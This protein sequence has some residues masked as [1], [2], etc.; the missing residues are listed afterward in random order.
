MK[1]LR[2]RPR[3]GGPRQSANPEDERNPTDDAHNNPTVP[4]DTQPSSLHHTETLN[5]S[6]HEVGNLPTSGREGDTVP[7]NVSPSRSRMGS[8]RSPERAREITSGRQGSSPVV[9]FR[10]NF[11]TQPQT[12]KTPDRRATTS[13]M[14]PIPTNRNDLVERRHNTTAVT[15]GEM[16]VTAESTKKRKRSSAEDGPAIPSFGAEY[17][18]NRKRR[19]TDYI[20]QIVPSTPNQSPPVNTKTVD[21]RSQDSTS[22]EADAADLETA[23][24][25][26][27]TSRKTTSAPVQATGALTPEEEANLNALMELPFP[28][29][30][31]SDSEDLESTTKDDS[32][33]KAV[34]DLDEWIEERL[35]TRKVNEEQILTALRCTTMDQDLADRVLDYLAAGKGI[36][37]DMRGVW[38]AEDDVS[39]EGTDARDIE[40]LLKKHGTKLYNKRFKY[41]E[42]A[43][44]TMLTS[45]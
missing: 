42:I 28:P 14:S 33:E 37:R 41:L 31:T 29:I 39:L 8:A 24:R 40:R 18:T 30:L 44:A 34:Q 27:S 1:Y 5:G 19:A 10:D 15:T 4:T 36:P 12:P 20:P 25:P 2:G 43:R 13:R 22:D 6:S 17:L 11:L 45:S 35:R 21:E 9:K 16:T 23:P 26:Q 38:T 32:D 3:P 7:P